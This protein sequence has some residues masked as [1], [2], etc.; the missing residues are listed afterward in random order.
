[1]NIPDLPAETVEKIKASGMTGVSDVAVR[2]GG[3]I[4]ALQLEVTNR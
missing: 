1:M 3:S 2:L 4:I